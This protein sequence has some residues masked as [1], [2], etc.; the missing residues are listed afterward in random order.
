MY[1]FQGTLLFGWIPGAAGD[2]MNQRLK[3]E[4]NSPYNPDIE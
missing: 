3:M 2:Y 4:V 1:P